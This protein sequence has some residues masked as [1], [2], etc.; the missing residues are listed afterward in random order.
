M[1][2]GWS[3]TIQNYLQIDQH[4]FSQ[5]LQHSIPND[6]YRINFTRD[7]DGSIIYIL[8]KPEIRRNMAYT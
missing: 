7:R 1:S 5:A 4:Q 3:D 6:A 8:E 2:I